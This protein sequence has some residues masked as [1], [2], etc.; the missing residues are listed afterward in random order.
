MGQYVKLNKVMLHKALSA[1]VLLGLLGSASGCD[2]NPPNPPSK[3][4]GS[5]GNSTSTSTANNSTRVNLVVNFDAAP[6]ITLSSTGAS[7]DEVL[8]ALATGAEFTYRR[9]S[10]LAEGQAVQAKLSGTAEE[11]ID[12]LLFR[13][14]Y[15]VSFDTEGAVIDL[16][17]LGHGVARTDSATHQPAT[18]GLIELSQSS[19]KEY[20]ANHENTNEDLRRWLVEHAGVNS[21]EQIKIS[22]HDAPRSVSDQLA[23]LVAPSA[24]TSKDSAG[25]T[26]R[27]LQGSNDAASN[28]VAS[29]LART[30]ALA[31]K[32][33]QDLAT[34]LNQTCLDDS[35]AQPLTPTEPLDESA[36]GQKSKH[37]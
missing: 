26:P 6:N 15:V 36:D 19:V 1:S 27:H 24:N 7:T 21:A 33:V 10:G 18:E 2:D 13:E 8:S 9:S 28:D 16:N 20:L 37:P 12:W 31:R 4:S 17:W 11:L 14:D 22:L 5:P 29:A 32:N 30:T 34:A 25:T 3:G 35:C 23:R